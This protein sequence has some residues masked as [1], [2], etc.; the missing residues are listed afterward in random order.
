MKN[1]LIDE[2]HKYF[3]LS[4][5]HM[6]YLE[7]YIPEI[8]EYDHYE[9]SYFGGDFPIL[10]IPIEKKEIIEKISNHLIEDR[11]NYFQFQIEIFQ[12]DIEREKFFQEL[13][14]YYKNSEISFLR[15]NKNELIDFES[16]N[17]IG[18]EYFIYMGSSYQERENLYNFIINYLESNYNIEDYIDQ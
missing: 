12:D 9:F 8:K 7:Y 13:N 5:I 18:I 15:I 17:I 14:K 3:I 11:F 6:D 1:Y 10:Q 4:E 16:R 2:D